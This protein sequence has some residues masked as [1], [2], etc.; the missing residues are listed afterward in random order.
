[1][2]FRKIS[3]VVFTSRSTLASS[4]MTPGIFFGSAGSPNKAF[5]TIA[6]SAFSSSML[7]F[8]RLWREY[9]NTAKSHGGVPGQPSHIQ[10]NQLM[11]MKPT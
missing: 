6:T 5:L 10:A 11:Y 9:S 2:I 7:T 1:M 4:V 8:A 3:L